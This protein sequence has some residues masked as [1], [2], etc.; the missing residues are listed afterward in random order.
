MVG[1]NLYNILIFLIQIIL[2]TTYLFSQLHLLFMDSS[3]CLYLLITSSTNSFFEFI[4]AATMKNWTLSP[5]SKFSQSFSTLKALSQIFLS[6][7][8]LKK[9]KSPREILKFPFYSYP[10]KSSKF[11]RFLNFPIHSKFPPKN[12][13]ILETSKFSN[14]LSL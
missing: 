14:S 6:K 7:L 11:W 3:G 1:H 13:L 5:P 8:F 9:S 4:T 2:K 12:I 10:L